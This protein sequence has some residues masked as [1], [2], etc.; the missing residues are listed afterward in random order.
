M[1]IQQ[2]VV[3]KDI[4]ILLVEGGR[5]NTNAYEVNISHF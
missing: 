3:A 5:I 1:V 2:V 4:L